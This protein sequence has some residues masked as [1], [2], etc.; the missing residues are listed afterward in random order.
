VFQHGAFRAELHSG[1]LQRSVTEQSDEVVFSRS[2]E[3]VAVAPQWSD[4]VVRDGWNRPVGG[5]TDGRS[6]RLSVRLTERKFGSFSG[7]INLCSAE[8]Q[9]DAFHGATRSFRTGLVRR[10]DKD[11]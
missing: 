11:R 9:S 5:R 6:G 2:E 1:A 10:A 7:A 3:E 4:E 8:R